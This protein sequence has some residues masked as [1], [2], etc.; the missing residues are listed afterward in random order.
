MTRA[1]AV[2]LLAAPLACGTTLYAKDYTSDCDADNQCV[3]VIVGDVCACSCD[4]AAINIRDDDKYV[5]DRER[6]GACRSTCGA[7]NPDAGDFSCGSGIAAQCAA[8]HCATYALPVDASA[9]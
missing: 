6:I 4:L 3:R 1:I 8:G 5:S 2:V 9:E 7:D